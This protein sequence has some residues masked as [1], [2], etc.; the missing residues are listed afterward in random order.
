MA[1]PICNN[2]ISLIC[3]NDNSVIILPCNPIVDGT[4]GGTF[5]NG[6][7]YTDSNNLCWEATDSPPSPPTTSNTVNTYTTYGGDCTDCQTTYPNIP[8]VD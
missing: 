7:T 5:T 4:S 1:A 2:I 3:C 6:L 8:C